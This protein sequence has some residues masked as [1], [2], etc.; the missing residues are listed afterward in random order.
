MKKFRIRKDDTVI[1]IS[2]DDKGKIGKVKKVLR[3]SDRVIVEGVNLLTNFN[4][5]K[6]Y[7]D[8]GSISLSEGSIHVSNVA[9]VDPSTNKSSKVTYNYH[10]GKKV[11]CTKSTHI[12][13]E[14]DSNRIGK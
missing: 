13:I 7:S 1:V 11:R 5:P 4:K 10:Y 2:G 3:C 12:D 14:L 8:T 6:T 9:H